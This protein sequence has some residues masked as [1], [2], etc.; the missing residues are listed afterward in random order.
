MHVLQFAKRSALTLAAAAV[1]AGCGSESTP[2]VPFDPAGASDDLEAVNTTFASPAFTDF[3]SL[4]VLF[5][6]ALGGAPMV[7]SSA[8][9]IDLRNG[10]TVKG[11]Q[12]AAARSAERISR[13]MPR[14]ARRP[15]SAAAAS[16]PPEYLGK[17]FIYSN[18]SYVVTAQTGA[19]SNGVRFWLY[20][21]DPVTGLPASPLNQTGYVDIMDMSSGTTSAA[22]V[23]VVSGTTTYL[24]YRVNVTAVGTSGRVTVLGYITDG[25]TDATFNLRSTLTVDAGLTLSYSLDVPQRDLSIDLSMTAQGTNPETSTIGVTL[26]MRGQNGWVRMTGE[27]TV[28]GGTLNVGIN[29]TPFATI[30]F[31]T[32]G[33]PEITGA[34]GQ[35]LAPEEIETLQHLFEFSGEAFIAF[36]QLVLPVG[37]FLAAE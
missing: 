25:N 17:T 4:S 33:D 31:S 35:P 18:G 36:D 8:Q 16:I 11:A 37:M 10:G 28:N 32:G 1:M 23:V 21:V 20:A 3:A 7:S 29:G 19:P 30:A 9:A 13:M 27:F 15:I 6:A 12:A 2:T 22:R 24:D 26:D 34:D 14:A 5:D